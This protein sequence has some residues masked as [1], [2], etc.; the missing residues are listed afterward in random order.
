MKS[1]KLEEKSKEMLVWMKKGTDG[2]IKEN[3]SD[4]RKKEKWI[5]YHLSDIIDRSDIAMGG[6]GCLDVASGY[7]FFV[8]LLSSFSFVHLFF[9]CRHACTYMCGCPLLF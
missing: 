5:G 2:W 6:M 9:G 7:I 3:K 1:E 8:L 4:E